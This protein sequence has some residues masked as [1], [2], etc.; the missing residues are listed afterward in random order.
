MAVQEAHRGLPDREVLALAQERHCVLITEDND[1]GEWVFAHRVPT[2]E[3]VFLR[4]AQG[5]RDAMSRS[6]VELVQRQGQALYGKFTT[7][8]PRKTRTRRI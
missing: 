5:E 3:V 1:F 8:T 4:Y 2:S 7:I 6:V